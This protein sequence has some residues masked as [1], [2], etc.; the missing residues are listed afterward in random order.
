MR[1]DSSLQVGHAQNVARTW[2]RDARRAAEDRATTVNSHESVDLCGVGRK[3]RL[4]GWLTE[5]SW[6]AAE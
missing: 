5:M 2:L 1:G 4:T 6:V 3:L